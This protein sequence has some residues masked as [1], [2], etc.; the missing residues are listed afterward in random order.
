[1]LAIAFKWTTGRAAPAEITAPVTP[2]GLQ[3][4]PEALLPLRPN[5]RQAKFEA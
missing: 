1:M 5:F 2:H 3:C 4:A